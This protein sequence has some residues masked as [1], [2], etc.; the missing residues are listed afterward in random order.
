MG[1]KGNTNGNGASARFSSPQGITVDSAGNVYV[2]DTG[3][4]L[5]RKITPSGAV[6]TFAG[7]AFTGSSNEPF[8]TRSGFSGS[9][10]ITGVSGVDGTG[11]AARFAFPVGI[12]SDADGNVFVGDYWTGHV[13][14]ITPAG[15]VSTIGGLAGSES[16]FFY[17]PAGIAA[18]AVGTLYVADTGNDRIARG[19]AWGAAQITSP[20]PGTVLP[21]GSA[22]FTWSAGNGASEY[23]LA[24]GSTAGGTDVYSASQG[25]T[26]NR[27]V[28]N[29]PGDG[30]T[31]Y[32][33][34]YSKINGTWLTQS[35]TYTAVTSQSQFTG[36]TEGGTLGGATQT[37]TWGTGTGVT[38]NYLQVG[39]TAGGSDIFNRSVA[40]TSQLV[41]LPT[42][43]RTLYLTLWSKVNGAW[44]SKTST[45]KA[46]SIA[47]GPAQLTSVTSGAVTISGGNITT[48]PTA[49]GGN[50][51]S[52]T[53]GNGYCWRE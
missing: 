14:K 46:V 35:Y 15:V 42:D 7:A 45:A 37:F 53:L 20:T 1:A 44:L 49:A 43:G 21:S 50:A 25:L 23:W 2:A 39:S 24:V 52:G 17:F 3:N 32:V 41:G 51:T 29:L 12:E 34:L 48:G 9:S 18:D 33:S 31:L 26:T 47:E 11:A 36:L 38:E 6:S 27:T 16:D 8:V 28:T 5:I 40:G 30:R 13:R 4:C 19:S 22:P 10:D